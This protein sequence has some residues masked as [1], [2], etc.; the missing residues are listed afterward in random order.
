M[1]KIKNFEA[2]ASISTNGTGLNKEWALK[3]AERRWA[4]GIQQLPGTTPALLRAGQEKRMRISNERI[5]TWDYLK[6]AVN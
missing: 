4:G 5:K 2:E 3:L 1:K 6:D